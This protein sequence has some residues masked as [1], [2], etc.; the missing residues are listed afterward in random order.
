M[1]FLTFEEHKLDEEIII[2]NKKRDFLGKIFNFPEWK[3]FV[4]EAER[5]MVFDEL[6]LQ[7][8]INKL[9]ELNK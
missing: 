9:K 4:F 6:C 3:K 2:F 5:Y 8:I 1:N 7:E